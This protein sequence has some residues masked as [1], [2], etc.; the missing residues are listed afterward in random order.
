MSHTTRIAVVGLGFMGQ[1]YASIAA[2]L[3]GA[4]LSAVCDLNMSAANELA[5]ATGATAYS[6]YR[7]VLEADAAD[8]WIIALPESA[9]V[10]PAI[11]AAAASRHLLIEKPVASN[12][13]DAD[14]LEQGI[15]GTPGVHASA[16]L[17]RADPRY[18]T[19][20]EAVSALD[21]GSVVHISASRRGRIS[22][23]KRVAGRTSLLYYLGVHDLDAVA[24]FANS[25][26]RTVHAL[27]RRPDNWEL[28][29]DA[30]ILVLLEC[31]NGTI[32][33]LEFT[34]AVADTHPQGLQA[35]MTVVG[36]G[37]TVSIGGGDEVYV[38]DAAGRNAFDSLFWPT[39]AG[40]V[41]GT[42]RYQVEQWVAAV[43]G[44][45]SVAATIDQGLAA[46]RVA[47]AIEDSL[48]TGQPALVNA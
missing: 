11:E 34:W 14:L 40:R 10:T 26:I 46:S 47:F 44:R 7:A 3:P 33:Q 32:G 37:G 13:E 2:D 25:P 20:A 29:V 1:R 38:A 8:A 17:L 28:D 39:S 12:R 5:E 43:Q 9:Q 23:A 41:V 22:T 21:F 36:A 31:A 35:A 6:D 27:G 48:R 18:L 30:T 16:H 4:S 45:G 19:A 42:L 24:W 15:A